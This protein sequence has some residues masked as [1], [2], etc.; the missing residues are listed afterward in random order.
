MRI[1]GIDLGTKTMGVA[2]SDKLGI[3]ANQV[4]VFRFESKDYEK[5]LIFFNKALAF[6]TALESKWGMAYDYESL[7]KV[8]SYKQ[9]YNKA[10]DYH[11]KAL[12]IREGLNQKNELAMSYFELGKNHLKLDEFRQAE[13]FLMKSL[14]ISEQMG[15]KEIMKDNYNLL[16]Q[17]YANKEDYARALAFSKKLITVKDSLYDKTKSKQI[18]ELQERFNSEKRENEIVA[19]ENEAQ[20]KELK[21]KEETT[22]RNIMLAIAIATIQSELVTFIPLC[23]PS[24]TCPLA[25]DNARLVRCYVAMGASIKCIFFLP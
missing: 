17:M 14:K 2:V 22:F 3:I 11:Y 9:N 20:I 12:K 16:S 25:L 6:D 15:N 13:E 10:L 18:Q 24:T 19:L 21:I 23:P 1:L 5:A 7:G 8:S 4:E